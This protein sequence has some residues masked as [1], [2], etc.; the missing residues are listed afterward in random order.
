MTPEFAQGADENLP[1]EALSG[2][3]LPEVTGELAEGALTGE[4]AP[5]DLGADLSQSENHVAVAAVESRGPAGAEGE[6]SGQN[7]RGHALHGEREHTGD[8]I[9]G[10]PRPPAEAGQGQ[11]P[12]GGA[13]P[14]GDSDPVQA[15]GPQSKPE[16]GPVQ[17][18]VLTQGGEAG[19]ESARLDASRFKADSA[20]AAGPVD[21]NAGELAGTRQI[22]SVHSVIGAAVNTDADPAGKASV[23]MVEGGAGEKISLQSKAPATVNEPTTAAAERR[24]QSELP[25][26]LR[27]SVGRSGTSSD[28]VMKSPQ[29]ASVV[30]GAPADDAILVPQ[31]KSSAPHVSAPEVSAADQVDGKAGGTLSGSVQE[32]GGEVD[33]KS[34][35]QPIPTQVKEAKPRQDNSV[36]AASATVRPQ[37]A[38]GAVSQNSGTDGASAA[39][40]PVSAS[41]QQ[42]PLENTG[43]SEAA[44]E[45]VA[46]AGKQHSDRE[47]GPRSAKRANAVSGDER[48]MALAGQS[49]EKGGVGTPPAAGQAP[50]AAAAI[51]ASQ[52]IGDDTDVTLTDISFTGEASA[53]VRGGD[54]TG[55]VRTESLQTPNQAQSGHVSTQVAAEIV[56]N[57]KNGQTKFQ[58]RFDPPELGRVEVNMKVAADGSVQ[59]HLIVERPETL[60]MFLRDQRGLER[61]LEAAGLNT[62]SGNLQFSLK[63]DGGGEF[64]SSDDQADQFGGQSGEQDGSGAAQSDPRDEEVVRLS[65]AAQR[66]GLDVKI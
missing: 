14:D 30:V 60:D 24:W 38:G 42:V 49:G 11:A 39:V 10:L 47:S 65:L 32:A 28:P 29:A 50:A 36:A 46:V 66:G 6:Q 64:A 52:A 43:L 35:Q 7:G 63:Q 56:R 34:A 33:E 25:Q 18:P 13:R 2:E 62:D 17:Q 8:R 26:E 53:T 4:A 55:A 20:N 45:D 5:E 41:S 48:P 15:N 23:G 1:S 58:M 51:L 12:I 16:E 57:L 31:A 9:A 19:A 44:P 3:V 61:A 37:H 54:L 59:A 22:P 40:A 27:A 21:E